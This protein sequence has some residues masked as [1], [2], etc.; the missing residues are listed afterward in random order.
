MD[1]GALE[2]HQTG[3]GLDLGNINIFGIPR[4]T[5]GGQL[6]R[7]VLATIGGND[8]DGTVVWV[9]DGVPRMRVRLNLTTLSAF[10]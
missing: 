8:L 9:G 7:L 6:V 3:Q 1:S 5:L 10:L 4:S 2:G